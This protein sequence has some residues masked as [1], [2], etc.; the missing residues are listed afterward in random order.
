MSPDTNGIAEM[1]AGWGGEPGC[2]YPK[3]LGS[4]EMSGQEM[5]SWAPNSFALLPIVTGTNCPGGLGGNTSHS[6]SFFL[7]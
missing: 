3:L 5:L 6:D 4:P 7:S 2:Q 1:G